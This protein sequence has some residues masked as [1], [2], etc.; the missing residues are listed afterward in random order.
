MTWNA[1]GRIFTTRVASVHRTDNQ[2]L[3]AMVEFLTNPGTLDGLPTMYYAAARVQT[4][5]IPYSAAHI[6]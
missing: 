4:P 6:L 2:R 1:F 3:H 5:Q